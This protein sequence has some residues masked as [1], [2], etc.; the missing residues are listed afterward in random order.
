MYKPLKYAQSSDMPVLLN[1]YQ[2]LHGKPFPLDLEGKDEE[3][4]DFTLDRN[5]CSPFY[6]GWLKPLNDYLMESAPFYFPKS[7]DKIADMAELIRDICVVSL[8][9]NNKQV[10]LPDEDFCK[11][12]IL[13]DNVKIPT[14]LVTQL[15]YQTFCIDMANNSLFGDTDALFIHVKNDKY[16]NIVLHVERIVEEI[17]FSMFIRFDK[18][19][20]VCDNGF[21]YIEYSRKNIPECPE[22]LEISADIEPK[23]RN[24]QVSN[25]NFDDLCIFIVQFLLYLTAANADISVNEVTKNTYKKPSGK[26]KNKFSEVQQWEVGYRIGNTIRLSKK[27]ESTESRERGT[28]GKERKAVTPHVRR[29]HWQHYHVGEGRKQTI[30]KWIGVT[31]VGGTKEDMPA[32][33]HRVKI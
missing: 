7:K 31:F 3:L 5:F 19:N 1:G 25:S 15:P 28:E 10:Y 21:S 20:I 13:T 22:Y 8:W 14:D 12:L 33:I 32:T 6:R 18:E 9:K 26:P 17:F 27:K 16:G 24:M 4:L 11:E 23:Y 30:R 29:A 2:H